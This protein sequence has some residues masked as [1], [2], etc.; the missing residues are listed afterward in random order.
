MTKEIKMKRIIAFFVLI[1]MLTACAENNDTAHN[2][3]KNNDEITD[4]TVTDEKDYLEGIFYSSDGSLPMILI[5]GTNPCYMKA[6][7][8]SVRF[9]DLTTGDRIRINNG[10]MLYT[11]PGQIRVTRV[12]KIADGDIGD[13]D[14]KVIDELNKIFGLTVDTSELTKKQEITVLSNDG[15]LTVNSVY[16]PI[17]SKD[18]RCYSAAFDERYQM[19]FLIENG[20]TLHIIDMHDGVIAH[21]EILDTEVCPS[22]IS[23][24]DNGVTVF[25]FTVNDD[26]TETVNCAYEISKSGNTFIVTPAENPQAYPIYENICTSPDGKYT[27]YNT[28]E[29]GVGHGGIDTANSNYDTPHVYRNVVYDAHI[30]GSIN[31][32][33]DVASY[34]AVGF[35]SDTVF[36]YN[37]YGWEHH[38]GF[39]MYDFSTD[40]TVYFKSGDFIAHAVYDGKIMVEERGPYYDVLTTSALWAVDINGNYTQ[41]AAN[42][43]KL[44]NPDA[45][46]L[47]DSFYAYFSDGVWLNFKTNLDLGETEKKLL[48][49]RSA[50]FTEI[51]A[52][53][54]YPYGEV[55]FYR[56]E[57]L[58]ATEN[59]LTVI[60]FAVE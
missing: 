27:I 18:A 28:T 60:F 2:P 12:E 11:Y 50:D 3:S 21:T 57:N 33:K 48:E 32:I 37:I 16:I 23:Y 26:N 42:E 30:G 44:E 5:N 43:E 8:A 59:S 25:D 9:D 51:L 34:E 6:A 7:D 58:K 15:K 29:D 19:Y 46:V 10:I 13:I 54:E 38:I 41:L 56:H 40:E 49:V 22:N 39:G 35:I 36:V 55:I 1:F 20:I 14:E 4:T 17:E 52:E 31:D 47:G 24:G 45:Y 53:I